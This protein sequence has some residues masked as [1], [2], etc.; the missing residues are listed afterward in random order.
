MT[1]SQKTASSP[2]S[3]P[4]IS[5]R[6]LLKGSAAVALGAAAL[7]SVRGMAGEQSASST[8]STPP[9]KGKVIDCHA[10]LN[11][12]SRPT[13][14]ADDRKLIEAAD[15]LGIDQLCC[16]TLTSH[17][18]ATLDGFRECNQWTAEGMRRFSGRVL[19][20]CYVN[21]GY[22]REA[23]E[24]IRRYVGDHGF[25]GVKLYNEYN[26]TEPVVFPIVEL[27]IELGIPILHHASHSHYFVEDQPRLTD[28]GNL[29]EL[30]RRYPEAMLIC[31]HFSGGG[32][33]EWTIKA[34]RHAPNLMLDTSG[35]VTDDG[36]VD[37]AVAVVG[38]DRVVFGCDSSMT[39]GVGKIRG[40]ELSIQDKAKIL[41]GNMIRLLR[42]RKS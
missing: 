21:P 37:L 1:I 41:G 19:G 9:V 2:E 16:S 20:Y 24:E 40:A 10:H 5:R 29:A 26:C 14:E 7:S 27:T 3:Q 4:R 34:A 23:L 6:T 30:A 12:H 22:G 32:D 11:H 36:S 39:A 38:A 42:R 25:M 17:W 33:W 13:W 35:S 18:P 8:S 31:A 15:K 28:S